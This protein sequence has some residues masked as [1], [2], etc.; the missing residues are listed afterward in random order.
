[1]TH[2][3]RLLFVEVLADEA[4][5]SFFF[6]ADLVTP[7]VVS[8][9]IGILNSSDGSFLPVYERNRYYSFRKV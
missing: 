5:A 7:A 4:V 9:E 3:T 8:T 6:V 1:M 2:S